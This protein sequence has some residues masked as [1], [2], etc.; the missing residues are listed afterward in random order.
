MNNALVLPLS[1]IVYG[2]LTL[3]MPSQ[4]AV[5]SSGEESILRHAREPL[6]AFFQSG[7]HSPLYALLLKVAPQSGTVGPHWAGL[8]C[9][10]AA[11]AAAARMLRSLAGAHASPGASS[12]A[13]RLSLSHSPNPHAF[14]PLRSCSYWLP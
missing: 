3:Y 11:I 10:L 7:A 5:L 9:G 13:G 1:L 14:S 2:A 12:L 8:L 6:Q 4:S